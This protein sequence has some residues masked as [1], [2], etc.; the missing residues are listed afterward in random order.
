[1]LTSFN[2]EYFQF[3]VELGISCYQHYRW[4]GKPTLD[5]CEAIIDFLRLEKGSSLLDFG[6]ARGF[7]VKAFRLL[8][9]D[10][11]GIDSSDYA[12]DNCD[13]DVERWLNKTITGSRD[14][15]SAGFCKDVMEHIEDPHPYLKYLKGVCTKVLIIVPL[16]ENGKYR[17]RRAHLDKTHVHCENENWWA[18]LFAK[19]FRDVHVNHNIFGISLNEEDNPQGLG[20]FLCK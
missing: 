16:G 20:Y 18:D 13:P 1:M 19:Y 17:L 9:I 10:A 11:W 2:R 3:G 12:I 8:G 15:F 14:F 7:Y 4:L 6:C 5:Y